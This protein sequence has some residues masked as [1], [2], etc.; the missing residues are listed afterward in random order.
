MTSFN[1]H[2]LFREKPLLHMTQCLLSPRPSSSGARTLL[3][4]EAIAVADETA[5]RT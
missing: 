2:Y 3:A 4:I 5:E 1:D